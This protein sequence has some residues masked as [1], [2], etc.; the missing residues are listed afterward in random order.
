MINEIDAKGVIGP[1]VF[2]YT[3][4]VFYKAPFGVST[5]S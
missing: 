5:F 3:C 1:F 2:L 4:E